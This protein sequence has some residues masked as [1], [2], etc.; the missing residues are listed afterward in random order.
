MFNNDELIKLHKS[1]AGLIGNIIICLFLI[2]LGR[3]YYLQIFKGKEFHR[4]SLE[5]RL[6]EEIVRAPRGKIY[7]RNNILL[8]DNIPRFDVSMVP[9]FLKKRKETFKYLSEIIDVPAD[10]IEKKYRRNV[11][12]AKYHPIIIKKNI[13]LAEITRIE[14]ESRSLPGIRV[15]TF[16]SR[17]YLD[18]EVSSHVLGYI[19][20]ISSTQLP[21]YRDRDDYEY[22]IGDFIGQSGLEAK[23]NSSLRGDNGFQFVEVDA[24]GRVKR[25]IDKNN[26]LFTNLENKE[27]SPGNNIE[28]TIDVDLQKVAAESLKDKTGGV[29]ALDIETGEILSMVSTPSFSP[30]AFSKGLSKKYWNSII[31]NKERPLRNRNIQE[32][33]SPGSTFK[34]F[35]AIAALEKG[36][37]SPWTKYRCHGSYKFGNRTYHSW[38]RWGT[39]KVTISDALMQSCNIYFYKIASE[40]DIDDLNEYAVKFGFGAKSGIDLYNEVTG[41]M[42]SKDW[43]KKNYGKD[44]QKGETLSCAI[45]QS[46]VLSSTLQLALAYAAIA[47]RGKL[48]KPQIIRNIKTHDG[49]LVKKFSKEVRREIKLKKSTWDSIQK[50]LYKVVNDPKGTAFGKRGSGIM[51]A[52][53]TGTSQVRKQSADKLYSKCSLMP[54]KYRHHGLFVGFAPYDN[55]KIAVASIVEHG[56]GGSSAAAPIVKDVVTAYMNKYHP[57]LV[58]K[59]KEKEKWRAKRRRNQ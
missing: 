38:K 53:K 49:K 46:Y 23:H 29:I 7:S 30:A 51:M 50:G 31:T 37:I 39:E 2:V 33:Y 45:G 32:H 36:L 16:I 12:A 17:N 14:Q 13:T 4:Y 57:E 59:I 9:Q 8:V 27:S 52:G 26:Q 21:K 18:E 24:F 22:R 34:P 6:R 20:E 28:L 44:W 10:K 58:E 1:R 55:P 42:P 54:Y 43:K 11:G 48:L 15:T 40:L 56:C 3:L 47:N 19:A 35:T 25:Y 5:N 41:L